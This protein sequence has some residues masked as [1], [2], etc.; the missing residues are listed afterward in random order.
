MKFAVL[1]AI[2]LGL[3]A[4]T[5]SEKLDMFTGTWSGAGAMVGAGAP[6]HVEGINRCAWTDGKAFLVCQ[7]TATISG[8]IYH[9]VSIY[10]YDDAH[11]AYRF[12]NINGEGVN[13]PQ[14]TLSGNTWTYSDFNV[15]SNGVKTY[16]R[17]L[18]IFD[19]PDSYRFINETS[20]DQVHWTQTGTGI[21]KRVP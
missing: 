21:S 14:L 9:G 8:K 3:S 18:N 4:Q 6:T 1:I 13:T 16:T 12:A 2:M 7:G 11:G 19:S 10:N 5:P 15:D 20:T 17:T